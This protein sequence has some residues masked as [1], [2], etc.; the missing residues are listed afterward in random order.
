MLALRR[1]G[2]GKV[3]REERPRPLVAWLVLD[4]DHLGTGVPGQGCRQVSRR[5]GVVLLETEDLRRGVAALRPL[6]LE[7]V[8]DLPGRDED[9]RDL[10]ARGPGRSRRT[11]RNLPWVKSS[12]ALLAA[13]SRSIDLGVKTMSGRRGRA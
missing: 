6:G 12:G 1:E 13:L 3:E 11:G 4:D 7:V 5:Q 8:D 10:A 2:L 9:P